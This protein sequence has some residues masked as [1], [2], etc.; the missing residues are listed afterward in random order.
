M[1]LDIVVFDS[2]IM[3]STIFSVK[4]TFLITLSKRYSLYLFNS[5]YGHNI[6]YL[7]EGT[8]WKIRATFIKG[9]FFLFYKDWF[10]STCL[11]I[12]SLDLLVIVFSRPD[13][14]SRGTAQVFPAC[15]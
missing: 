8:V 9:D 10:H 15:L 7:R 2:S 3:A 13:K 4:N 6:R 1:I 11:A 5:E 12:Y 14:D